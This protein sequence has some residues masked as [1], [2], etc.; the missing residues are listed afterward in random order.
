MNIRGRGVPQL[1]DCKGDGCVASCCRTGTNRA[2]SSGR[3][4]KGMR[5]D[6]ILRRKWRGWSGDVILEDKEGER[7]GGRTFT[8]IAGIPGRNPARLSAHRVPGVAAG[9]AA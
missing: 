2:P 3:P 1:P 6:Y 7:I 9:D 5:M 4:A 8:D